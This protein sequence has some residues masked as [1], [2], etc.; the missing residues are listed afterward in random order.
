ME[1]KQKK[2]LGRFMSGSYPQ[3]GSLLDVLL[4]VAEGKVTSM[5]GILDA[6]RETAQP[7][8]AV[9]WDHD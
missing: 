2:E 7:F 8:K 6:V 9:A 5:D 3:I 4:G 1:S